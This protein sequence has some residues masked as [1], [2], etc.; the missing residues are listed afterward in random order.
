VGGYDAKLFFTWEEYDF[1]LK[2]IARKWQIAYDG[3]MAVLHNPAPAA[4]IGW[5]DARMTWFVRNRLLISR[6]WGASWLALAPRI[7]GYLVR[8]AVNGCLKAT[9]RG[10]SAAWWTEIPR[11]GGMPEAMRAY[12]RAH[13]TRHRGSW[14]NRMVREVFARLER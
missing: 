10:I 5:H 13:E 12:I 6:K 14:P 4:R 2:A 7:T 3:S 8:A 1:C 9:L 11:H